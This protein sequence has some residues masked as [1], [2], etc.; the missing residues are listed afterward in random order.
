MLRFW[1]FTT[2]VTLVLFILSV[3][4]WLNNVT[5]TEGKYIERHTKNDT[6]NEQKSKLKSYFLDLGRSE[7]TILITPNNKVILVDT[8][9]DE[10]FKKLD[11]I[12]KELKIENIDYLFLTTNEPDHIG[13]F[14]ELQKKYNI[15]STL[16]CKEPGIGLFEPDIRKLLV[17]SKNVVLLPENKK[18][19][20]D[21]DLDVYA[22]YE[23]PM[24]LKFKYKE[25]SILMMSDA[26]F[27][28]E[29]KLIAKYKENLKSLI[30]KVG[31]HGQ[32]LTSSDEFLKAVNPQVAI[33]LGGD[34]EDNSRPSYGVIERLTES[35]IDVYRND[36]KGTIL[37]QLDGE[38]FEVNTHL[39][40]Y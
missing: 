29:E 30:L 21:D 28:I 26:N 23:H 8:G 2:A 32:S 35:W 22:F 4:I 34:T 17:E 24:V 37:V 5:P 20:L 38:S 9:D 40:N 15:H 13:A 6:N 27:E 19:T 16:I 3:S 18:L 39:N 36:V 7:A 11:F 31:N 10:H 14:P 1:Y 25:S 33:I 12:L